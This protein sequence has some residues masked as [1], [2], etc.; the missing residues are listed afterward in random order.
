[1]LDVFEDVTIFMVDI[2][3][4][5]ET[6]Q[7]SVTHASITKIRLKLPCSRNMIDLLRAHVAFR[8]SSLARYR[9]GV[10]NYLPRY[11]LDFPGQIV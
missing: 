6:R 9:L 11:E 7:D 4:H 8:L 3:R 1:M 2:S 10:W 5:T